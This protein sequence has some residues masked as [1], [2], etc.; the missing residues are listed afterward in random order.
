MTLRLVRPFKLLRFLP[1]CAILAL[2]L[3]PLRGPLRLP[4][5]PRFACAKWGAILRRVEVPHPLRGSTQRRPCE[6]RE[7]PSLAQL[8][9]Q[10]RRRGMLLSLSLYIYSY[11]YSYVCPLT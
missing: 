2:P 6:Q 1:L 11:V 7:V 10:R 8:F 5:F 9:V 4:V 3:L